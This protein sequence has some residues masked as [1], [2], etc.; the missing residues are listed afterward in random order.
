MPHSQTGL[1]TPTEQRDL[2]GI[3]VLNDAEQQEYFTFDQIEMDTL[4]RFGDVKSAVYFAIALV[5]FKLKRTI[6]SF[7]YQDVTAERQ[8][9]MKRYFPDLVSPKS[10]PTDSTKKRIHLKILEICQAKRLTGATLETVKRDLH[11]FAIYAPRQRQLLKELLRILTKYQVVIPKHTTLQTIVSQV[12]NQ[13]QNRIL[14]LYGRQ[15]TKKQRQTILALLDNKEETAAILMMKADLKSFNTHDLWKEIEKHALL[16]SIFSISIVVLRKLNLPLTTY[17]YYANLIRYYDRP[18]MN[19]MNPQKMGLYLLCYAFTRYPIVNDILIDAF[20]KRI[21]EVENDATKYIKAQQLKQIEQIKEIREQ[22]S[23]MMLMIDQ[24]APDAVPKKDMYE[25]VAQDGWEDAALSLVDENFD[26]P[27]LFWKYIDILEDSIKLSIRALFL[28]ID[29]TIMQDNPLHEVAAH[30]KKHLEAKTFTT[31]PF[32]TEV[33]EWPDKKDH[34]YI[35]KDN[36]IIHNRFEFLVYKKMLHALS[37]NKIILQHTVKYKSVEDEIL[38]PKT[39]KNTKEDLLKKLNYPKLTHPI[40]ETLESKRATLTSLYKTVNEAIERG[41]NKSVIIKKNK[42]GDRVWRLRPIE[43][44]SDPNEGLFSKFTQHSIVEI[45]KFADQRTNFMRTFESI[46]PKGT[47]MPTIEYIAAVTLA[48]ATRMGVH[49]MASSSDLN[50]SKLLTTEANYLC[51]ETLN[52]VVDILNKATSKFPIFN[53]WYIQS[54]VHASLDALKLELTL[55]HHKG[56]HSSKYFGCGLGVS[57]INEIVNGLSVT[58]RL[59][60]AHEYEGG[61]N[62]EMCLLQ[63]TSEI[64]PTHISTDKHGINIFNFGFYDL[65]DMAL[66]PRIPKPHREVLWGFGKAEDYEGLLIKPTKFVNEQLLIDEE[67]NIKRLMASFLTGHVSPSIVIQKMSS[68]EYTSKTKSAL[69]QYNNLEKSKFILNTIHDPELRYVIT[70]ILNRGEAYNNLYRAI[71][72]LND[73][74]LRGKSEFEMEISNQC[75]R[76]IAAI[77]HY[78]NTYII[79]RLYEQSTDDEE[80]KFLENLSPTAWAHILFLGFFQFLSDS[81]EGWVENCLDQWDWKNA[82]EEAEKKKKK[83]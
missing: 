45:I 64:K 43:A 3:P 58:G 28:A 62:F 53:K 75:T 38:D 49:K 26:K 83:K 46:L 82:K 37:G 2:Y 27:R 65:V 54:I 32:P 34:P 31:A 50:E 48:N 23:S 66:I 80:K 72:I 5:F 68:K 35:M 9:V 71:T 39:W 10:M 33:K 29:F 42:K 11:A 76:F 69:I 22:I 74:E 55:A 78:Y 8:H 15:T 77:I 7:G 44:E 61:F 25:Y 36:E 52:A 81:P 59:I 19:R 47:N 20:K 40:K 67:D 56:R 73:G 51:V 60:G 18:H 4:H 70:K 13:E 41:D 12:W 63:N 30:V 17:Q 79:N 1:L 21:S 24:S 16:K 14:R 6:I 57:S